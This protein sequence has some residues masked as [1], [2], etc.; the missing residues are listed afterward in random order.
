MNR[1]KF[2]KILRK[3]SPKEVF[4]GGRQIAKPFN[5]WDVK[6]LFSA[7]KSLFKDEKMEVLIE[8]NFDKLMAKRYENSLA[9]IINELSQYPE[10][11]PYLTRE[12]TIKKV[13]MNSNLSEF[14]DYI[15]FGNVKKYVSEYVRQNVS[16][17]LENVSIDKIARSL[18]YVYFASYD[19]HLIKQY[20]QDNK[21]EYL[22]Y[23]L[24]DRLKEMNPKSYNSLFKI[25]E[26]VI[27]RIATR[28]N[29]MICDLQ[30][31]GQG[32]TSCVISLGD[33]IIKLGSERA[34]FDIPNHHRILQPR[35]RR[36]LSKEMN[37]PAIIEVTDRVLPCYK[38]T[39][40]EKYL[41]YKDLRESGIV[42]GDMSS[43]N[44]GILLKD[45]MP[46]H[47]NNNGLHGQISTIL[48]AGEY[49]ILDNDFIYRDDDPNIPI[50]SFS[51]DS[52]AFE[53]RYR[54]EK[55]LD[56]TL[57]NEKKKNTINKGR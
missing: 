30:I 28:E 56:N 19:Q 29:C 57:S 47:D 10:M 12:D 49:V 17:L 13:I 22:R 45:N 54:Q 25:L 16:W 18:D 44:V 53:K 1:K 31:I 52:L 46:K 32:A 35:I 24:G 55:G 33:T 37:I 11:M 9:D 20:F 23:C 51:V 8:D 41:I 7:K 43:A 5:S 14:V 6:E 50:E 2:D 3:Y 15:G 4:V 48:K 42:F 38:I 34:T 26:T 36:D 40:E 27:D 21:Q 39:N